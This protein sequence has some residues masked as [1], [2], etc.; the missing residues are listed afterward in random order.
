MRM[1]RGAFHPG[2]A[3]GACVTGPLVVKNRLV[4]QISFDLLSSDLLFRWFVD[5]SIAD[6]L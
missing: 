5:L 3:V 2:E 6:T 4:E 1:Q